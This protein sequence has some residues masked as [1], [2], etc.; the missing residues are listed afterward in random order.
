MLDTIK[1]VSLSA[2]LASW[3]VMFSSYVTETSPKIITETRVEFLQPKSLT[4]KEKIEWCR[5]NVTCSEMS[6][7]VVYE[8]RN[9][10]RVGMLA[11]AAVIKNRAE[12]KRWADNVIDVIK[13][14]KQFSYL[15]DY[16]KQIPPRQ[17]DWN[18][19]M[20]ASFD[21][22]NNVVDSPVGDAVYYHTTQVNPYW[23]KDLEVVATINSHVFYKEK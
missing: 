17:R 2:F 5:K 22:L 16:K 10:N 20:V 9:Q 15:Q 18:K 21:V 13:E 1:F 19:A 23:A 3:L 11:V 14:P 6:E 8:S 4:D 7:A 12:H